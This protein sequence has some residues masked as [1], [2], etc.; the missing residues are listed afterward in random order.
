MLDAIEKY[1]YW[2]YQC[3]TNYGPQFFTLVTR[4]GC[5]KKVT[6]YIN[7]TFENY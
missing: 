1:W 5:I 3:T 4:Y 7:D 6:L 2:P